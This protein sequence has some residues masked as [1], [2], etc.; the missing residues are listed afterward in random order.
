MS[1]LSSQAVG[2]VGV[3]AVVSPGSRK[4][5]GPGPGSGLRPSASA[6]RAGRSMRTPG[7]ERSPAADWPRPAERG[8][9][10]EADSSLSF[11]V[12]MPPLSGCEVSYEH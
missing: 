5:A 7:R 11:L 3:V 4:S 12:S 6:V 2:V 10:F 9:T 1:G 8:M